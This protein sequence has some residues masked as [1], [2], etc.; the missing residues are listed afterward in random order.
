[1]AYQTLITPQELLPKLEDPGWLVVDCRFSLE[2]TE[3]G[4]EEYRDQHIPGAVYAHLDED[5][6]GPPT[7][8]RG[9]HPLPP[10]QALTARFSRLGVDGGKQVVGYDDSGGIIAARLWWMLR[11]MGHDDAAVLDGGWSAWRRAGYPVQSGLVGSTPAAFE[12]SPRRQMLVTLDQVP[13]T[14]LLIDSRAPARYRGE[15]EPYDPVAGHI[16]GAV[17]YFYESNLNAQG[18]FLPS[19]RLRQQ[20]TE[21]MEDE[22][23]QR[24]VYYCGSGV[25]A[26]HNVLAHMHAGLP[27]GRLYVG[28]WSEW[29][30][31]PER[32]VARS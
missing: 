1:M 10:P 6:S 4:R 3:A 9:R 20:L 21:R 31:D 32:P 27:E 2:D 12:G 16:P 25:S 17:N 5:L 8:D 14:R 19:K 22:A 29:C 11:Y 30:S 23:P 28:S 24:A 15:E 18:D 13:E 26:C 7:T